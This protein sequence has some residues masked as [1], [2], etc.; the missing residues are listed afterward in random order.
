MRK[1]WGKMNNL[2]DLVDELK[3]KSLVKEEK[4][5]NPIIVVLV[6]IGAIVLIAAAVYGVYRLFKP[7]YLEDFEDD[8]F[9]DE[10]EDDFFEDDEI[11]I[12]DEEPTAE[13]GKSEIFAE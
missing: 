11:I 13:E 10:F 8:E 6:I 3:L 9:E 4:K 1:E 7:D 2:R 5:C 12:I